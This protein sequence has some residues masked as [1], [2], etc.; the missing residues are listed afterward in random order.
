MRTVPFDLAQKLASIC[1]DDYTQN[2]YATKAG[3]EYSPLLTNSV[4]T[5]KIGSLIYNYEYCDIDDDDLKQFIKAPSYAQVLEWLRARDIDIMIERNFSVAKS[6]RYVIVVNGDFYSLIH[7]N[8]VP[9]RDYYEAANDA[10]NYIIDKNLLYK[11][12]NI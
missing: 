9:N 8:S 5:T 2:A 4:L 7:Q 12:D 10:I 1:F 6:Y 3:I 11:K